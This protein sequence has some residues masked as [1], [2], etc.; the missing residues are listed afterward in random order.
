[1][2]FAEW[3]GY[4]DQAISGLL[5]R[6]LGKRL[7]DALAKKDGPRHIIA[8][9]LDRLFRNATDALIQVARRDKSKRALHVLDM[10]GS[11]L[12]TRSAVGRAF[13]TMAAAFAEMER[14]LTSERVRMGM[15]HLRKTGQVYCPYGQ[16]ARRP[17][18]PAGI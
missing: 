5:C 1:L 6:E 4:R 14:N 13:F 3:D 11:A 16:E 10:G 2:R 8:V 9:K 15:A 12:N 17:N 18:W 7:V